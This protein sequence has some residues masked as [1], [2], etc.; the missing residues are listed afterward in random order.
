[1]ICSRAVMACSLLN[2][3]RPWLGVLSGAADARPPAA[4]ATQATNPRQLR[5]GSL[6]PAAG[7]ELAPYRR[8]VRLRLW[9]E[10]RWLCQQWL[11]CGA[12]GA[13]THP[14]SL[15]VSGASRL[16]QVNRRCRKRPVRKGKAA[17]GSGLKPSGGDGFEVHGLPSPRRWPPNT[18][19]QGW[20]ASV[21]H[22]QRRWL[23][24]PI[25]AYW[26]QHL[27]AQTGRR[28]LQQRHVAFAP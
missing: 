13:D 11:P 21:P 7:S 4:P 15:T 28:G 10:A 9:R 14:V 16:P 22:Q 26:F 5:S 12:E 2:M 25:T 1:M 6:L 23:A 27:H 18:T 19:S 8:P 24:R 17:R 3:V 20:F